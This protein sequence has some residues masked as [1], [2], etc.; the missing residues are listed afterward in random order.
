MRS[1]YQPILQTPA[2]SI[3]Y[4]VT[5]RTG[6]ARP[7]CLF[8][9][10]LSHWNSLID[11]YFCRSARGLDQELYE[12]KHR[13]AFTFPD[14]FGARTRTSMDLS[15]NQLSRLTDGTMISGR[16]ILPKWRSHP[17]FNPRQV[18]TAKG[19]HRRR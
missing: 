2:S 17:E 14:F 4:S 9:F 11:V 6:N 12:I 16:G 1:I 10:L 5:P 18:V 7:F 15:N 19:L 13:N 3:F 8:L